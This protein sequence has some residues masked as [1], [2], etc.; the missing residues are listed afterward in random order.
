[1]A[2]AQNSRPVQYTTQYPTRYND[3]AQRSQPH[4]DPGA[5]AHAYPTYAQHHQQLAYDQTYPQTRYI[6]EVQAHYAAYENRAQ[7][8][9]TP[10]AGPPFP[11]H[12][13]APP[14]PAQSAYGHPSYAPS[15]Y[16]QHQQ[17][18][19]PSSFS[20]PGNAY[21]SPESPHNP[22][23]HG[24]SASPARRPLPD[25]RAPR[26]ADSLPT[27]TPTPTPE[28][29]PSSGPG[30]RA[31]LH[32]P[33]F[34][35]SVVPSTPSSSRPGTSSGLPPVS[36]SPKP[37]L[38]SPPKFVHGSGGIH[39]SPPRPLPQPHTQSQPLIPRSSANYN[40]ARSPSPSKGMGIRELRVSPDV[41]G[42]SAG[43]NITL[44]R[45]PSGSDPL[46]PATP[47]VQ[48]FTPLWK[49]ALPAPGVPFQTQSTRSQTQQV[50]RKDST[51]SS[52]ACATNGTNVLQRTGSVVRPLP[53]S[54]A[55]PGHSR[56]GSLQDQRQIAT[57]QA[58]SS[59]PVAL[60]RMRTLPQPTLPRAP[61][62]RPA[63]LA[64]APQAP[65]PVLAPTPALSSDRSESEESTDSEDLAAHVLL[66]RPAH[67]QDKTATQEGSPQYGILDLPR[68]TRAGMT[69]S[70]VQ[71][72]AQD[73]DTGAV[74]SATLRLAE[75]A[76]RD[77]DP[78]TVASASAPS[79]PSPAQAHSRSAPAV[80]AHP[81]PALSRSG[82]LAKSSPW[83]TALPPLPRAP[84]SATGCSGSRIGEGSQSAFGR[85]IQKPVLDLSLDDEPPPPRLRSP[86]PVRAPSHFAASPKPGP[87]HSAGSAG[88]GFGFKS[89]TGPAN[90]LTS[91]RTHALPP[92][93]APAPSSAFSPLPSPSP[94]PSQ[95][96]LPS[97]FANRSSP[98]SSSPSGHSPQ[99][100]TSPASAS[101]A[102]TLSSFPR[103]PS[104][105]AP[106]APNR[107]ALS[108]SQND[109]PGRGGANEE[110]GSS[111]Q[112]IPKISFPAS[113]DD[114]ESDE[115]DDGGTGPV[116]SITSD[117]SEGP[118]I[119][120]ISISVGDADDDT[121][122]IP[123][124]SV[125]TDD[126]LPSIS[127]PSSNPR[128][129]VGTSPLERLI[130]KG[131][132]LACGG[133]GG[134]IVGRA[135]SAMGARWHPGCF[136]CCICDQLLENLSSYE[137]GGRAYC[138][139]DYHERFAPKCYHC[140]TAIVDER[141]ITLDDPELGKRTYHEQ[142]FFC[143]EC[144]DPF[145]TP[146]SPSRGP[147]GE[148]TFSG[149]GTFAGG[150]E[151]DVGF[152]VYRG[153]PYCEACHV[154]LR[155]PK[156]KKCRK[157]I[158]D[159]KRAVEALGGKWCWE[160]FVCASCERPF[161]NPSFFQRDGKPFCEH[162][163]S[164]MIKSEM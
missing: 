136:R 38:G 75:L 101:S 103:P 7:A 36:S 63:S 143:A 129:K 65:E 97:P 48:K 73:W 78:R 104:Y 49:R 115:S 100:A 135:V 42:S 114:D 12:S 26:R 72:Q 149:D 79:P 163:F 3:P 43:A 32:R 128:P 25:P 60:A 14:G 91:I 95:S 24:Q 10:Y 152:T 9:S 88:S 131:P 159:G 19:V 56:T 164:I 160:C 83:P 111:R 66:S 69:P 117:D 28:P 110:C 30:A 44:D 27:N 84:A 62:G 92:I 121:P 134:A 139:L 31:V 148:Q 162:C 125:S 119:P 34:S 46:P 2:M 99:S 141:F 55:S 11:S 33:S 155:L 113:A 93:P 158:R 142:H 87:S 106:H 13:P 35:V 1:M 41:N 138:H 45:R 150:A 21:P 18:Y 68:R 98:A 133:C 51:L 122:S 6:G 123:Q 16:P 90:G 61:A 116:I 146:S 29:T 153:H 4:Y 57:T 74:Q 70:V 76:L 85:P 47:T 147:P 151:D 105:I 112:A 118:V 8:V 59:A 82:T 94:S 77:R 89:N 144:G 86:S 109:S 37:G 15:S 132:G 58:P 124:I 137:E 140:K 23:G 50:E 107:P 108:H 120:Q 145:L 126:S 81:M 80:H 127:L 54:P 71:A 5:Q 157:P 67:A 161:E 130:R 20:P 156:C 22:F 40:L 52:V 53:Q 154:R 39:A 96:P 17:R 102:F 64:R